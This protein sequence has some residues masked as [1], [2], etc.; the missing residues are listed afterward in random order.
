MYEG[1]SLSGRERKKQVSRRKRGEA[2]FEEISTI[3]HMCLFMLNSLTH[4][5]H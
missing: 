4:L 3:H 2:S 5:V 1:A